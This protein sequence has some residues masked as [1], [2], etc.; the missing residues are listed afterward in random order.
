MKARVLKRR[1]PLQTVL[2]I[3]D[4][5]NL[6]CKHCAESGHNGTIMKPF[7]AIHEELK[8]AYDKGSRFVDFE[9]GE[10]ML[11]RD[12]AYGINDL[13]KLAKQAGFFSA[14]ITTNGQLPFD[15]CG[16]DS[17]WVSVDGPA[18]IHD[19]I[20]G[21]GTFAALDK[22]MRQSGHKALSINMTINRRNRGFIAD[23]V[24][25]AKDSP[26]I[27]SIS[28]NFHTPYPGVESLTLPW[29]ERCRTIDEI[30]ALK[31]Q[32]YPIMNSRSGLTI[33]KKRDFPKDC[34]VSHFILVDGARLDTCPGSLSGVCDDC[35]FC[36][37]GETYSVL[38]LKP[39]TIFSALKLRM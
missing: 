3:T 38:R 22:N 28:L 24:Q 4:Y 29:E 19:S 14:T 39:D 27:Q 21:E 6:R 16:A 32:G 12:G 30:L 11:W 10:P 35:G 31:Q 7:E 26:Y 9:G 1:D 25:Y 5:C 2:F 34:W 23:T 8:F 20:R 36:M 37:A 18:D 13:V 17:I 33:M 15:G